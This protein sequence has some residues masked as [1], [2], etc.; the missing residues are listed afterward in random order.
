MSSYNKQPWS[1]MHV[2]SNNFGS[3]QSSLTICKIIMCIILRLVILLILLPEYL[4][5]YPSAKGQLTKVC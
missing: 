5:L 1:E 2:P 4:H 3:G